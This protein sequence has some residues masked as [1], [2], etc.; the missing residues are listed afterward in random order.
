MKLPRWI[1]LSTLFCILLPSVH[2]AA[3]CCSATYEIYGTYLYLQPNGS[4]LYYG[5]EAI[6]LDS[7]I[8]VPAVSP[9]WNTF[10]IDSGYQS[11]FDVGAR[12]TFT[13]S[14]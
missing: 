13:N 10:E 14:V 8:A 7:S 9:N 3:N 6:P 5:V 1:L 4:D 11:G 12:A 2:L